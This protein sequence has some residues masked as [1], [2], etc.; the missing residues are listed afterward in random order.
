MSS[1][2]WGEDFVVQDTPKVTKK[3]I[4]KIKKPKSVV[5]SEKRVVSSKN[6]SIKDRLELIREEVFRILGGYKGQTQTIFNREEL[7]EYIDVALS[8]GY[9]AIDTE[10]NNTL[11]PVGCKLMGACIYTPSCKNAYI[12]IN[13]VN[14]DTGERL[15]NQLTEKDIFEEFSRQCKTNSKL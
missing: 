1:S 9:I 11:Q 15:S 8:N 5:T 6:I 2:L 10:T 12:P 14:V 3:I 4:Q 13:H 7:H